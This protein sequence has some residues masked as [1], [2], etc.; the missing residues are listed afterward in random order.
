MD[1][2][3]TTEFDEVAVKGP[4]WKRWLLRFG[5]ALGVIAALL[6]MLF[7]YGSMWLPTQQQNRAFEAMVAA[8]QA[9]P[10]K[11]QFH[12]PIPGCVCHSDDPVQVALHK[13]RRIRECS[14]C[15]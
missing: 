7:A 12:I 15:H 3:E 9:Q 14:G 6:A 11:Q 5:I 1:S 10:V 2:I 13:S 8:G 4:R